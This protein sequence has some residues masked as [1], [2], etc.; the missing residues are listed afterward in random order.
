MKFTESC[1]A[2]GKLA[3]EEYFQKK[4]PTFLFLSD[5]SLIIVKISGAYN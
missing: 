4:L 1:R 5:L 2:S 3:Y